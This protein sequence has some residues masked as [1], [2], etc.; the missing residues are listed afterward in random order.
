MGIETL[1]VL[2]HRLNNLVTSLADHYMIPYN[3]VR[4]RCSRIIEDLLKC[5]LSSLDPSIE[6]RL[7]MEA[8]EECV[9]E[10]GDGYE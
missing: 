8:L 1:T 5:W 7:E 9:E 6:C 10:L 3:V 4:A 2:E